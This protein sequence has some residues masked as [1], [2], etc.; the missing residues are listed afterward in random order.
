MGLI[1]RLHS[2]RSPSAA[3]LRSAAVEVLAAL[4]QRQ[5]RLIA[6]AGVPD[7]CPV[8]I[9]ATPPPDVDHSVSRGGTAEHPPPRQVQAAT[10]GPALRNGGVVPVLLDVPQ[11]MAA[12]GIMNRFVDVRTARLEQE[13]A[14]LGRLNKTP[15][16]DRTGGA[17][18][19]NDHVPTHAA[20]GV[21]SLTRQPYR[22]RGHLKAGGPHCGPRGVRRSGSY[23]MAGGRRSERRSHP[24][25]AF[26]V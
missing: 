7:V 22:A 14:G 16:D 11:L 1:P 18:T 17:R 15:C 8:V 6:P 10:C 21:G 26:A 25:V 19:D 9:V 23:F 20:R 24:L 3:V 2:Q 13:N 5:N 4:E 12:R